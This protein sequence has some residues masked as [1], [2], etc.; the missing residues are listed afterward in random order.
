MSMIR[1]NRRFTNYLMA[2]LLIYIIGQLAVVNVTAQAGF[3]YQ[4]VLRDNNGEVLSSQ[5]VQIQV[6]LLEGSP[7][8]QL[9]Y[10]ELH[11]VVTNPFGTV[12]VIIGQGIDQ[13]G[14]IDSLHFERNSY[15]LQVKVDEDMSGN[16]QD[17]GVDMIRPVPVAM[18]A[19]NGTRGE[20]GEPGEPG[21]PGE[22]G[23]DGKS[24]RIQGF[25]PSFDSL[26]N[27]YGGDEGDIFVDVISGQGY[28]WQG[29]KWFVFGPFR[30][31]KGDPGAAGDPGPAG[32]QGEDGA[33]GPTG[34]KGEPGEKGDPGDSYW[35]LEPSMDFDSN[36]FYPGSVKI[37]NEGGLLID[38]STVDGLGYSIL[39][40]NE[41]TNRRAELSEAQLTLG[42]ASVP[43]ILYPWDSYYGMTLTQDEIK[44]GGEN[45]SLNVQLGAHPFSGEGN[46]GHLGVSDDE[47]IE[48]G[49]LTVSDLG[50]ANHGILELWGSNGLNNVTL[51]SRLGLT[52]FGRIVVHDDAGQNTAEM[53]ISDAKAGLL[54]TL[55]GGARRTEFSSN[56][57]GGY[58]KFY[59]G[60]GAVATFEFDQA[61]NF[62]QSF[63]S[64][65]RLKE[66]IMPMHAILP[67]ILQITPS[68]FNYS[69]VER[70][71][72]TFGVI[73]QDLQSIFPSLVHQITGSDY[74]GVDY[75]KFGILAIQ[76]IKEQQTIIEDLKTQQKDLQQRMQELEQMI[77][78][79]LAN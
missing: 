77:N 37:G 25:T 69:G 22:R 4:A 33:P 65:L 66:N 24:I 13:N 3:N 34:P 18:Y 72:R 52:D 60:Q 6:N 54:L 71:Y 39:L 42:P 8:G 74:L 63:P 36:L 31:P 62:A 78:K 1:V 9:V 23:E 11:E 32:P 45:S 14:N 49:H 58:M 51:A 79:L 28:V 30:G 27:N 15:F 68:F 61:G 59:G 47:G 55:E 53:T 7:E 40:H 67:R 44:I 2:S 46:F 38:T 10:R 50:G 29:D 48:K 12:S 21:P 26:P 19:L 76:A 57:L 70:R 20:K 41:T 16:F 17:F 56:S 43:L 75:G 73:A 35:S 5:P 64:D